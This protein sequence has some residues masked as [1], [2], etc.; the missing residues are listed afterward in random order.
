ML[1]EW[2]HLDGVTNGFGVLG[3]LLRIW[4][5]PPKKKK[6]DEYEEKETKR[7]RHAVEKDELITQTPSSRY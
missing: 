2:N 5:Y 4:E 6:G 1:I 3:N 7:Q